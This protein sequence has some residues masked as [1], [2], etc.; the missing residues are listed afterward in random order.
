[1]IPSH[2]VIVYTNYDV[3]SVIR[4]RTGRVGSVIRAR[5]GRV[6]SVI[7]ARTGR[8]VLRL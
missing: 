7:R 3:G 6:G 5:T 2:I 8:T 1:M 4:A